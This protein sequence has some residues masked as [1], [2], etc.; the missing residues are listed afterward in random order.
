[1]P[2]SDTVYD[3]PVRGPDYHRADPDLV[4]EVA[5]LSTAT[6]CAKLH[7]LGI[8]RSF[9]QGP[10]AMQPGQRTAGTA[11]TLQF[12]PQREDIASGQDQEYIERTTALWSV[13]E[14]VQPGDVLVV[15]ANADPYTGCLGDIL[16]SYF[17][18][19]GGVGI[20][21]DGCIRDAPKIRATSFPLWSTGTTPH[22]ASQSGWF[23]W[24]YD[25][26]VAVGG[27]LCLPGDIV[28]ADDDGVVVVPRTRA[29][30]LVDSARDHEDWE[31]FSRKRLREGGRLIDYYPLTQETR[32]EYE[33]WCAAGR[34]E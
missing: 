20:V 16:V 10:R 6:A 26:P 28:L 29:E 34:P 31:V 1:M 4:G 17:A 11:L 24:A 13:L 3:L 22:Y 23:P 27:A 14:A 19:Q 9:V 2:D 32:A 7:Q 21:V 30:A 15:Q 12:L 25:V 5:N 33:R 8:R 18:R